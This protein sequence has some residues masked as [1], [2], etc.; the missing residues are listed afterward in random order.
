MNYPSSH[1]QKYPDI[2]PKKIQKK[3]QKNLGKTG[4]NLR[5]L[6]SSESKIFKFDILD[7]SYEKIEHLF[8][9]LRLL[10]PVTNL[11]S[12]ARYL[13]LNHNPIFSVWK[14]KKVTESNFSHRVIPGIN[15]PDHFGPIWLCPL[16]G[17]HERIP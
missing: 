8:S 13:I 7:I 17:N 14:P 2:F 1:Q 10:G 9:L 6:P 3:N 4:E 5:I 11:F 16:I 12:C 15:F